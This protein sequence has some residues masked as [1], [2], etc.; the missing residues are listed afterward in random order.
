MLK[1]ILT[2]AL[3][4]AALVAGS[5]NRVNAAPFGDPS[6]T[7]AA[8]DEINVVGKAQ[9]IYGGFSYCWYED[10]WRGPGWYRCGY[11][12]RRGLGWGGGVGWQGWSHSGYRGGRGRL[13]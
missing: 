8:F 12:L 1:S 6:G 13:G 5:P 4:L 7:R 2:V 3:V 10:G 11:R 9:Y